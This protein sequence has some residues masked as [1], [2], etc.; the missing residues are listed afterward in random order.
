MKSHRSLKAWQEARE[1]TRLIIVA[2]RDHW[3]PW[4]GA[5]FSQ[6]LRSSLSVQLN[7]A[8]GSTYGR[9]ATYAR[10][11]G[12]AYGSAVETTELIEHLIETGVLPE[13]LGNEL[14]R[15]AGQSQVLLLGLLKRHRPMA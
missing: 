7:L 2:A 5:L 8:E 15:R 4:A 1:V 9:S 13:A 3:R 6:V 14:A 12:I 10:H 11:L